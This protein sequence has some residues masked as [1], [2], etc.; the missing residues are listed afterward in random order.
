MGRSRLLA[1]AVIVAVLLGTGGFL[2][3]RLTASGIATP[4]TESAAAGFLRDM[5]VHHAQAVDMAMTIRDL[6]DDP[7]LRLLAYDIALGQSSQAG[8]MYGLLDS[9]GLSQASPHPPMTWMSQPVLD[10]SHG[11][12]HEMTSPDGVM[13]GMATSDQLDEL[14]AATGVEAEK[15]FLT[16]MIEHHR[17]GLEMAEGVLAR[18]TVPQVVAMANGILTSQ[19]ADIA[20]MQAMLDARGD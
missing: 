10:G 5:Q 1:A 18:T 20:A 14:R 19:T 13:P 9:W 8:Q 6:S 3:G 7:G 17:G 16:L 4:S 15:L 2:V 12:G 11:G